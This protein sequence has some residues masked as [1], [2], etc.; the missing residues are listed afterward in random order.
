MPEEGKET[1]K[2]GG[3]QPEMAMP[4]DNKHIKVNLIYPM[5]CR[6]DSLGRWSF[7]D[8]KT[9]N[10]ARTWQ[11][12]APGTSFAI[13]EGGQTIAAGKVTAVFDITNEEKAR[14]AGSM[15]TGQKKK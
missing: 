14:L 6:H 5:V 15:R 3:A 7:H 12:L 2:E 13:R 1:D 9:N 10:L 11:A 4:G 8:Q